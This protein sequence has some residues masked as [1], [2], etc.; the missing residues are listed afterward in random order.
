M[1]SHPGLRIGSFAGAP[2]YLRLSWF[3][4]M[5]LV[6]VG[7]G[8]NLASSRSLTEAQGYLAA[9]V[10]AGTL[11]LGV[12]AHELAH[13]AVGRAR[14]VR[15]SSISLNMWGGQTKMQTA[16]A[17]TS[18]LVSVAGPL[19]NFAVAALCQLIWWA[20]GSADFFG[21][22]LA[23]Q[24]NLA[25]GIFNLIPAF[26]LDGGYALEALVFILV[27]RR[28][29]A[30]RVTAYTGLLLLALLASALLFTGLWRSP[31]VLL[32]AAALAF[33]LWSG[34]NHSLKQLA[35]DSDSRHPLRASAL[36]VPAQ[37]ADP[38]SSI[39]GAHQRWD[40]TSHLL[41]VEQQG[42]SVRPLAFVGPTTLAASLG[43]LDQ[44][45]LA[46]IAQPLAARTLG[47][48]TG[49]IDTL[50]E[51]SGFAHYRLPEEQRGQ[52]LTWV[53]MDAATPVGLVTSH[54]ITQ[55]VLVTVGAGTSSSK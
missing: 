51:Y 40:G 31:W 29:V 18:L 42:A 4:L 14:G 27:G 3:P 49:Y 6:V 35:Q 34:T 7:Y 53:V 10:V 28:S 45:P 44:Q 32:V 25:I 26:P 37:L 38:R 30:T 36:M 50:D 20:T 15:I 48:Q 22:A 21:F 9:G 24:V 19:V 46:A 2:I 8:M 23:A 41:L 55:A 54:A 17:A 33:Y 39:G 12:F 52:N 11:A 5:A 1:T 13:A 43:S 16:S 47:T